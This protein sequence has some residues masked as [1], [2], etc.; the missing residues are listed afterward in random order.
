MGV[1]LL[2]IAHGLY[3]RLDAAWWLTVWLL[4]A[5]ILLSLL[6]GFDYEEAIILSV[7]VVM[8]VSAAQP[9]EATTASLIDQHYSRSLDRH[10]FRAGADCG[11]LADHL[12][13]PPCRIRQRPLVGFR[14]PR[15]GAAK[16]PRLAARGGDRGGV[17][18]LAAAPAGL[19]AASRPEQKRTWRA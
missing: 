6:K 12:C 16:S 14:L 7:V 13:L 18:S 11:S 17:R 10:D 8:L 19:A 9:L 2:V 15:V 1:G 3:R 5:G 4:C